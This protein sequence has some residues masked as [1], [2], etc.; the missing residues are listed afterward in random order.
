MIQF[1][2]EEVASLRR[3]AATNGNIAGKLLESVEPV[4]KHGINIPDKAV[5]TWTL[6]YYC[7]VHSVQLELRYDEG[8]RHR[9]PVCD[10]TY[11]GEPYDG[12][13]WRFVNGMN[14]DSCRDLALL[15]MLTGEERY[16]SIAEEIL[17][18]YAAYYPGYEIHGGIPYNNPGKA[19]AQTLCEAMWIRS[20]AMG[21]DIIKDT[22]PQDKKA[23]IEGDLFTVCAEFL[24]QYR[25]DQIHNHEVL[26]GGGIAMLGVLLDRPDYVE[27]ALHSKYGLAY[28][29]E[30]AV[31]QDDF[32]FEGTFHYH[33]FALEAFMT[34]EKFARHTPYGLLH[35]PEYRRMLHMPVRLLQPGLRLP[36]VGDGVGDIL[37]KHLPE[38]YEFAYAVYG[39]SEFAWML[40]EYYRTRERDNIEAYLYGAETLPDVPAFDL[41]DYHDD[42]NSGFTVIRGGSG[43]K[44]LLMKHG[45]YGGEHD[46]Y[47][48]LGI[49][50]SAFGEDIL[51]DLGTTGYGALHHYGYYKNTATH[52][53][54][55]INGANQPPANGRTVRYER[56]DGQIL[57]EAEAV[58]DGSFP[59]IDSLTRV[60][61][62]EAAYEG[63]RMRRLLLW[64]DR[65]FVEAFLVSNATGRTV[66]WIVHC[67]GERTGE[68]LDPQQLAM[69]E[70]LSADKP[71]KYV[72]KVQ[73]LT[74]NGI[75]HTHWKSG[76]SALSL[77][78]F[79]SDA[80]TVIYAKGPDNPSTGELSYMLNRVEADGDVLFVNVF[81]AYEGEDPYIRSVAV[82]WVDGRASEGDRGSEVDKGWETGREPEEGL[83]AN[84]G[85]RVKVI[86][87]C[88]DGVKEHPFE[89][90]VLS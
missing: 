55:A 79:C 18:Q 90:G 27:F 50:F 89:I 14:A 81:E 38:F 9:C 64:Q 3:K 78:S 26:V 60:E 42:E 62:D 43:Q 69:L 30:H 22:L 5:A 84:G 13:W 16:R 36:Q 49:H 47:D 23:R 57:L 83:E 61:W 73:S 7:P 39:D 56:G 11:E 41:V 31:L 2:E 72:R 35:R 21:Y 20:L 86:L 12:A 68:R 29:L 32:W 82:Q 87:T 37:H 19:N 65:Y 51:P 85:R 46:H 45:R 40:N 48:K 70:V 28:Q 24:M 88:A 71:L 75:V 58:W 76:G 66:D 80:S 17:L 34:F 1:T 25:M 15:W 54:V 6:F 44:Y 59:G 52:N 53:T 74:P 33:Y 67:R 4:L 8:R 10:K 63:V 77:F